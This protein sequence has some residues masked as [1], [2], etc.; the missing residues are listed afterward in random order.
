MKSFSKLLVALV[1]VF[2][3]CDSQSSKEPE[4]NDIPPEERQEQNLF[5]QAREVHDEMMPY[6]DSIFT[7]KGIIAEELER[8][9]EGIEKVNDER[10]EALEKVIN[11]LDGARESMFFWMRTYSSMPQDSLSHEEAIK[12]LEESLQSIEDSKAKILKSL[13]EAEKIITDSTSN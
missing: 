8:A 4:E 2:V 13:E 11:E 10:K 1:V 12:Y 9:T 3:A 5:E 6:I 7:S